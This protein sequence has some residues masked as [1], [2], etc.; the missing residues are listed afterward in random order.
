MTLKEFVEHPI[1]QALVAGKK[2]EYLDASSR[3]TNLNDDE[4]NDCKWIVQRLDRLRIKPAKKR[5]FL[6]QADLPPMFAVRNPRYASTFTV[7]EVCQ[8]G[9]WSRSSNNIGG[10]LI[11]FGMAYEE[12]LEWYD[13]ET[14]TWKSFWKE[15]EE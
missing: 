2:C 13:Q 6:K 1:V 4:A 8:N 5:A 9:F 7:V 12:D 10:Q 14:K 15:V 3:W 11:T